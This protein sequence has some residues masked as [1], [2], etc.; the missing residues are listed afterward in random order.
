[1]GKGMRCGVRAG[2]QSYPANK[3]AICMEGVRNR[4][5]TPIDAA[6]YENEVYFICAT[7]VIYR[8]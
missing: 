8:M 3:G 6:P 7:F 1:M 5:L 4:V 2:N